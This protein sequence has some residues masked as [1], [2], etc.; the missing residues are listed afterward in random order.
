MTPDDFKA[1][2]EQMEARLSGQM[3]DLNDANQELIRQLN[4]REEASAPVGAPGL[5][6][7]SDDAPASIHKSDINREFE[8]ANSFA[9]P[10]GVHFQAAAQ[11]FEQMPEGNRKFEYLR[12]YS[13]MEYARKSE[14][15]KE[16]AGFTQQILEGLM[17]DYMI[18]FVRKKSQEEG[19]EMELSPL[20]D[21][22]PY[23]Q[24][25]WLTQ[26]FTS[27]QLFCPRKAQNLGYLFFDCVTNDTG[28]KHYQPWTIVTQWN[29]CEESEVLTAHDPFS[30]KKRELDL[31]GDHSKYLIL[32]CFNLGV[33]ALFVPPDFFNLNSQR[34][35]IFVLTNRSI[36]SVSSNP[37]INSGY[38]TFDILP[39][40][41]KGIFNYKWA[42]EHNQA[43]YSKIV[44]NKRLNYP[45]TLQYPQPFRLTKRTF[46]TN[47]QKTGRELKLEDF[48]DYNARNENL[49]YIPTIKPFCGPI[50]S[51]L[52]TYRDKLWK[53]MHLIENNGEFEKRM[54]GLG[55]IEPLRNDFSHM[56]SGAVKMADTKY[57]AKSQAVLNEIIRKTMTKAYPDLTNPENSNRT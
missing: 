21:L 5:P 18:S 39:Q 32:D 13:I 38:A 14:R 33:E 23:S 46:T 19:L 4:E 3:E 36:Q 55:L 22:I 17:N 48:Y 44:L 28:N 34:T 1:L 43:Y 35:E 45:E 8:E 37:K 47:A 15:V 41:K 49:E 6:K 30:K 53:F 50:L 57:M 54:L 24:R 16:W 9:S 51:K 25:P 10:I 26:A 11:L 56:N 12:K 52:G 40:K 7:A 42:T 29:M 20:A 27:G 31:S 2:L